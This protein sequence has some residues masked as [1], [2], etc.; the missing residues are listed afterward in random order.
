[1]QKPSYMTIMLPSHRRR[2]LGV[3]LTRVFRRPVGALGVDG[4]IMEPERTC[5]QVFT[6]MENASGGA[7]CDSILFLQSG[8]LRVNRLRA[9]GGTAAPAWGNASGCRSRG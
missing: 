1:M 9:A 3:T 7:P 2:R 4:A 6:K 5:P 8:R